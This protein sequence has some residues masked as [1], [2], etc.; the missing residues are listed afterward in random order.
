MLSQFIPQPDQMPAALA[1]VPPGAIDDITPE[2][3]SIII[4][5]KHRG[6]KLS[7]CGVESLVSRE[8]GLLGLYV[9]LAKSHLFSRPQPPH[10]Y[11]EDVEPELCSRPF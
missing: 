1:S 2:R 9:T 11:N 7:K 5:P 6:S 10:W 3:N 4:Y 8:A